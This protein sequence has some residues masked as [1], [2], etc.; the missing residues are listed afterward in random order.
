[1]FVGWLLTLVSS[2]F[3]LLLWPDSSG[4]TTTEPNQ[5]FALLCGIAALVYQVVPDAWFR[6][7]GR[8][9][10]EGRVYG[11]LLTEDTGAGM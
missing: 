3:T 2:C 8:Q 4:N 5:A 7:T 6:L 10:E 11:L 1:M 9:T